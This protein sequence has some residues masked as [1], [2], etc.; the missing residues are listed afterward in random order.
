MKLYG[1]TMIGLRALFRSSETA[2]IL[3]SLFCGLFAGLLTLAQGSVAH[4][5]Q[6]ILFGTG[7]A[8]LSE[9]GTVTFWSLL[10]LPFG[11]ALIAFSNSALKKRKWTPVD[12]VEANSLMG[13]VIPV[14][15][16]SY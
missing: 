9:M 16:C 10:A 8:R 11:G 13:G 3:L 6:S 1:N 12:D 15:D 4:W 2:L 7:V 14:R 5:I